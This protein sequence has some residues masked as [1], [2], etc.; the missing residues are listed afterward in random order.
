MNES[1]PL[2][3]VSIRPDGY[4]KGHR[5]EVIDFLSVTAK[6]I[7]DVGCGTGN[8]GASIKINMNVE[9][10]GIEIDKEAARAAITKYNNVLVGDI[11]EVMPGLPLKY[12]DCIFLMTYLSTSL[13][14]MKFYKKSRLTLRKAVLLSVRFLILSITELFLSWSSKSSGNIKIRGYWIKL[15]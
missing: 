13:F 14:R 9:I 10:W 12:F 11:L 4:F 7:L 8:F 6:R 2:D 15:I 1:K 5:S 3:N